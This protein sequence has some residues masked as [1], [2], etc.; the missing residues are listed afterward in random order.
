MEYRDLGTTGMKISAIAF[1]A[2]QIGDA[3]Y[4]GDDG[5]ADGDSAVHAALDA[6]ITLFDT[7]EMYGAGKSEEAD[8]CFE[9]AHLYLP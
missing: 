3:E 4:W 6:G 2:W 9:L 1:G 5:S 7:A 8:R